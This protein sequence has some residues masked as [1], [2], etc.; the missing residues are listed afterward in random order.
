MSRQSTLPTNSEIS[1]DQ[2]LHNFLLIPEIRRTKLPVT[3]TPFIADLDRN[4]N[5]SNPDRSTNMSSGTSEAIIA[6]PSGADTQ[7]AAPESKSDSEKEAAKPSPRKETKSELLKRLEE[8]RKQK[9][10]EFEEQQKSSPGLFTRPQVVHRETFGEAR[11][12]T[13]IEFSGANECDGAPFICGMPSNNM[14]CLLA[15]GFFAKQLDLPTIAAIRV[16]GATPE[17]IVKDN[18]PG[19]QIRIFG[20]SSLVILYS[21]TPLKNGG[22]VYNLN[23][24]LLS[25]CARHRISHLYIVDGVP[26]DTQKLKE[27]KDAEQLRFLTTSNAFSDFM[28]KNGHIAIMNAFMPGYAGQILADATLAD[29]VRGMDISCVLA[30]T[31]ARMPS[32]NS[33]V[34]VVRALN[35]FLDS[36]DIDISDLEDSAVEMET[37]VNEVLAEAQSKMAAQNRPAHNHMYM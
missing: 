8:K 5:N 22:L 21:E 1:A 10:A 25:F 7:I 34:L 26:T 30:K 33:A 32:A 37:T 13:L 29:D 6:V 12:V 17:G 3:K 24:A 4:S 28:K 14:T 27:S 15:A 16:H 9:K 18:Q 11:K 20:N 23:R 36:F 2:L 35:S 31:D 19:L